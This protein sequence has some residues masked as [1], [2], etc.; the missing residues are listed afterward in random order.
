M[1]TPRLLTLTNEPP[2]RRHGRVF[3]GTPHAARGRQFRVVFVPGLA[4]RIFPQRL[5]E[6]AL[7]VDA[8]RATLAAGLP[9]ADARADDERLQLRLAVGAAAERVYLSY[10]RLEL[11]ESRPRVPSFYVLDVLRA[12]TGAIPRYDAL[13]ADAVGARQR[14][15]RLAGTDRPGRRHRRHGARPGGTET[16]AARAADAAGRPR[17]PRPLSPRA[18]SRAAPFGRRTV[19]A[20]AAEVVHGRRL[21][22]RAAA[23]GTRARGAAAH[24]PALLA[25]GAAALRGVSLSVPARR[26]LPARAARRAGAVAAARSAHAR[27]PVPRDPDRVLPHPGEERHAA[28]LAR[29]HRRRPRTARLGD[30]ASDDQ[31]LR[32]SGA[33]H[34]SR[35]ARRD[36][37]T[38][39]RPAAVVRPAAGARC[40]AVAARAVRVR[41]RPAP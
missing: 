15:A 22:S 16:A 3:V 33:G 23:H 31:G 21:D 1:L 35:L 38:A 7:L 40:R 12:T 28:A 14:V 17:R 5:R 4:E 26:H 34:R 20:L 29:A 8:R 32:R 18:E 11:A 24:R 37:G 6:D 25:H 30:H 13:A 10:P 27:Q 2:R 36:R 9:M 19:G 39:P 41:L